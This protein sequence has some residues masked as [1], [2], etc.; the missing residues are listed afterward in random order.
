M[1][2]MFVEIF[3]F[4]LTTAG[5][6][7]ICS[8]LPTDYWKIATLEGIVL[9]TAI[10]A[11]NL[12][13]DC[14]GDSTGVT[15]CKEFPSMLT[16]DA[17]IQACR[18]LI[19]IAV[20]LGFFGS[21]FA[22]FGMKCTKIGGTERSK[23]RTACFGGVTFILGGLCSMTACSLY[24]SKIHTDFFDPKS[25]EVKYDFGVALF[26][27]W[28]GSVL[29]IVGGCIFCFSIRKTANKSQGQ[30]TYSKKGS[31][32]HSHIILNSRGQAESEIQWSTTDYSSFASVQ[33]QDS[34]SDI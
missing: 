34:K 33:P 16:L 3:A 13:K 2:T 28:G 9:G 20:C 6:A 26:I 18:A 25:F 17:H 8:T 19:I 21:V 7:L 31:A 4:I 29:C 11:S 10:I 12:W 1:K 5:W 23:A 22:L 30:A 32:S 27:G 24:A 14:V 15:D